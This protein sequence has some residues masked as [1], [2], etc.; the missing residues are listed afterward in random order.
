MCKGQEVGRSL[1]CRR[2]CPVS[3]AGSKCDLMDDGRWGYRG[4]HGLKCQA[5]GL[6]FYVGGSGGRYGSIS[7]PGIQKL[8]EGSREGRERMRPPSVPP[9]RLPA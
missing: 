1:E 4:G 7:F 9:P 3:V 6:G 5:E 8:V 2:Q